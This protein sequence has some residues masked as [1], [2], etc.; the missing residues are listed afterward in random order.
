M[1]NY[2]ID[3]GSIQKETNE[4]IVFMVSDMIWLISPINLRHRCRAFLKNDPMPIAPQLHK[5]VSTIPNILTQ[6]KVKGLPENKST[7]INTLKKLT[8]IE[9]RIIAGHFITDCEDI[10]YLQCMTGV[11]KRPHIPSP[12]FFYYL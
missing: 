4:P 7:H 8:S 12:I 9:H 5:P 3:E 1:D 10:V 2:H 11:R 6:V